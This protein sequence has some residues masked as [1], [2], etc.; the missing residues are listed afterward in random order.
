[1]DE[2]INHPDKWDRR[3]NRRKDHDNPYRLFSVGADTPDA[4]FF[5]SF[6][7]G[8]QKKHFIEI[9]KDLFDELNRF[10]LEDLSHLNEVDNHYARTDFKEEY[11]S[12]KALEQIQ[13]LE[14]LVEI[15]I[16]AE[17]LHK[18]III[19]IISRISKSQKWRDVL[20]R[21]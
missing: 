5:V 6:Q 17:N 18:A 13:S 12:V 4:H 3:P 14:S 11:L 8:L 15:K 10:E 7:D 20:N 19:L 1:M 16:E 2:K 21:Q 9:D